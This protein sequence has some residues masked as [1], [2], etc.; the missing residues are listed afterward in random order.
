MGISA[1]SRYQ[2]LVMAEALPICSHG[3]ERVASSVYVYF[4]ETAPWN[5]SIPELGQVPLFRGTGTALL[6][7]CVRF[8]IMKGCEG[9]LSLNA[10]PKAVAFYERLGFAN[11]GPD[12]NHEGLCYMI[13]DSEKAVRLLGVPK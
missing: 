3:I 6:A 11:L 10:L 9:R 12:D 4:L 5:L 8:S 7:T 2:G 1:E 13:L